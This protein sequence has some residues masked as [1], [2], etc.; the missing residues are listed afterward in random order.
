MPSV[1]NCK[2]HKMNKPT[3]SI[4]GLGKVGSAL[5]NALSSSG[6]QV[7]SAIYKDTVSD[8]VKRDHPELTLF[9][10]IPTSTND[11]GDLILITVPDDAIEN[12]VDELN[13]SF[14]SF[15]NKS[16]AHCSGAHSSF[17]LNKLKKKGAMTASF[18]PNRSI[19]DSTNNFN[20]TWF[21]VEGDQELVQVLKSIVEEFEAHMFEIKA[22]QKPYLHAS[23]VIASNYLVVLTDLI[24][25]VSVMG[26]LPEDDSLNALLP[27]MRNTLDNIEENGI[28]NSL[29][30]PIARGDV[31]TVKRHLEL[32]STDENVRTLYLTLGREALSLSDLENTDPASFKRL[33]A[34]LQG[35]S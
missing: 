6:Y 34:L 27:L 5:L 32:L 14:D 33:S 16:F 17:I 35:E 3:V 19:T 22:E 8:S 31:N 10:S 4:I 7:L 29:T 15:K 18:H 1:E 25:K 9:D 20:K 30:G 11:L 24:S 21:D 12:L 26:D 23:A 28:S 2:R 13:E